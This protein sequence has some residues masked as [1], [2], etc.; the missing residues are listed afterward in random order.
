MLRRTRYRRER[1][2]LPGE[3]EGRRSFLKWGLFGTV[4]LAVGGGTWLA[5]RRTRALPGLG[6][7]FVAL[8][9]L[10]ATVFLSIAERL[11]PV[12]AGFPR[13]M[14]VDLPRRVDSIVAMAPEPTQ[15]EIRQLVRLFDN[16]LAGFLLDGQFHTFTESTIEQQDARI[17]SWQQSRFALRRTGYK[18]LKRLVYAA[19]YGSPETWPAVGY[20]GPPSIS[21]AK[22]AEPPRPET[23]RSSART[24]PRPSAPAPRPV[25]ETPAPR[26]G[27]DLPQEGKP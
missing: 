25:E 9:P 23:A 18:A 5:T 21:P 6:G 17:A 10:E 27:M 1:I 16:A 22:P 24:H 19:Y 14:D 7:P 11:V 2:L 8:S 26:S 12:R 4:V 15:G 3:S 13:P 20:P